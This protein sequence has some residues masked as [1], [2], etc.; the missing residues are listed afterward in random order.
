MKEKCKDFRVNIEY[1]LSYKRKRQLSNKELA[2]LIGVH[3]STISRI[4][5]GEKGVGFKF[6]SGVIHHLEDI[7]L[8]QLIPRC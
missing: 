7:D 3:E 1:L 5:K 8:K 6:I 2:N 4:L